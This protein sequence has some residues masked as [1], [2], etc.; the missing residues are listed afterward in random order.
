MNKME[1]TEVPHK[2]LIMKNQNSTKIH[3]HHIIISILTTAVHRVITIS[4]K[5][6]NNAS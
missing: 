2:L 5:L 1:K 6:M 3:N 4:H